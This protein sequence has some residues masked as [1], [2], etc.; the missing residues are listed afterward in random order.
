MSLASCTTQPQAQAASNA[1]ESISDGSSWLPYPGASKDAEFLKATPAEFLPFV[2]ACKPWD[3]WDKPAPP[4]K[5]NGNTYYVGTCGIGAILITGG[6]GHVLIDTGT[7]KGA[8]VVAANIQTLG[9]KLEDVAVILHSHEHFDHVGGFAWMREQTGAQIFASPEAAKVLESGVTAEADPQAG[10]HD[11]MEPVIVSK[12]L[13]GDFTT[14]TPV[15]DM[16][17]IST[18]GHSPGALSWQWNSCEGDVCLNIVYADSL[19]PVSKDDYR[20]GEN[21]DY[22]AAYYAGIEKLARVD[23]DIL[24]TPHPSH[25]RMLK[26]MRNNNMIEPTACADYAT[27]K[28]QD[29]KKRLAKEGVQPNAK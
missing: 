7:R 5:I 24:I 2:E 25:S 10:M 26:R 15:E 12:I 14:D 22:L 23:C 21:P 16:T 3:D 27:G 8:E 20:F 6:E 13:T 17:F 18:P 11:P 29:I 28:I 9:F 19:S 4:F 1:A